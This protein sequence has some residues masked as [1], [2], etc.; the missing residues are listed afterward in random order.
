MER[1]KILLIG[2][3]EKARA[4]ACFLIASIRSY[5][6]IYYKKI[7]E[8][9]SIVGR[10]IDVI[11]DLDF[12]E[13]IIENIEIYKKIGAPFMAEISDKKILDKV[14]SEVAKSNINALIGAEFDMGSVLK[15]ILSVPIQN[16]LLPIEIEVEKDD[17]EYG[18]FS[19]G[20]ISRESLIYNNIFIIEIN[21]RKASKS[22]WLK[23]VLLGITFI[24]ERKFDV[25]HIFQIE[26]VFDPRYK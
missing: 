14:I 10:K 5:E 21:W 7:E 11:V 13:K 18:K 6:L 22:L 25:G 15:K 23:S 3:S 9:E 1:I 4:L 20:I 2:E 16:I 8:I 12:P 19:D 26:D 17:N 24:K